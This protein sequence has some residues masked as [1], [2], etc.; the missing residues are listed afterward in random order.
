MGGEAGRPAAAAAQKV[1]HLKDNIDSQD[2][3]IY[4]T[5][6]RWGNS[7]SLFDDV[8]VATATVSQSSA[9]TGNRF[10]LVLVPVCYN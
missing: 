10:G 6:H 8:A 5:T 9:E 4:C 7:H 3:R 1:H 2:S